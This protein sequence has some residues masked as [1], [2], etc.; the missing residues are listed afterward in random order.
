MISQRLHLIL[1]MTFNIKSKVLLKT[2]IKM[3]EHIKSTLVMTNTKENT[4]TTITTI[5][6]N[7][8]STTTKYSSILNRGKFPTRKGM[9]EMS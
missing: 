4:I 7:K 9:M 6:T 3:W 5:A 1:M 2:P 8:N